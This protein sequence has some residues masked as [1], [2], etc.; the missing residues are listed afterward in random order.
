ME[1]GPNA[2][3][4]GHRTNPAC[5]RPIRSFEPPAGAGRG[6]YVADR[7]IVRGAPTDAVSHRLESRSIARL[8]A[9]VE[10]DESSFLPIERAAAELGCR[11][12]LD[13]TGDRAP[14]GVARQIGAA[15]PGG[16]PHADDDQYGFALRLVALGDEEPDAREVVDAL[17]GR[18][19]PKDTGSPQVGLDHILTANP[20]LGPHPILGPH[21]ATVPRREW[22]AGPADGIEEYAA[23][24]RNGRLP[25]QWLAD[26]PRGP[27]E[28]E[29]DER[30]VVAILDTGVGTHPWFGHYDRRGGGDGAG[31]V[32]RDATLDDGPIGTYPVADSDVFDAEIGGMSMY[33]LGGPLDPYAG[34]GTFIAGIVHQICP[35]AAI[36][37]VRTFGGDGRVS[38]WDLLQTLR[39]LLRFHLRGLRGVPGCV[40]VDVA[41][42]SLGYYHESA[43]DIAYDDPLRT[44]IRG[45]RRAGVL[46]VVSAG[47]DGEHARSYPAAFAPAVDRVAR[48]FAAGEVLSR[49]FP[50]LLSVGALNPN[51]TTA[52]F[53]ND[54]SWI[55]CARPGAAV[56]STV[57]VTLNGS[58]TP[59]R[60]ALGP[61]GGS[62]RATFDID[63]FSGGFAV[64]SGTSFAAPALAGE[65]AVA[66]VSQRSSTEPRLCGFEAS[67]R[68]RVANAWRAVEHVTGL[69][70][71]ALEMGRPG[72]A[73]T[74]GDAGDDG[75]TFL[76][77]DQAGPGRGD[78]RQPGAP[79]GAVVAGVS[80]DSSAG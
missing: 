40:P 67:M 10:A 9:F 28:G 6:A 14:L 44:V 61:Y 68:A 74:P 75:V 56:V 60:L 49:E 29:S 38:E 43:A 64:W 3:S 22:S 12:K 58:F 32:L 30:V 57:P 17:H 4:C 21:P 55:T 36:L 48:C 51:G 19:D 54:G 20:V 70:Y 79:A 47:N 77:E 52:M 41:V 69:A 5:G 45:L 1:Y 8:V 2:R 63:D 35:D 42:L 27:A 15:G 34:H 23:I 50:P 33:P 7:V 46:V 73:G 26:R 59:S 62:P 53:S 65:L 13:Y 16:P 72:P 71:R 24:G 66:L 78:R 31:V 25:V 76:G 39:R 80:A 18:L 37:P 11:V